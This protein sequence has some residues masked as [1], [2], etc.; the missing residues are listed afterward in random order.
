MKSLVL[1]Q[2]GIRQKALKLTA[3]SMYGCLTANSMYGCFRQLD[4]LRQAARSSCDQAMQRGKCLQHVTT[5]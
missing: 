4:F 2:C 5:G 1:P 3:N